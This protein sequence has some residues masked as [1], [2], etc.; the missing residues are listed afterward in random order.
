MS[1]TMKTYLMLGV[2][3]PCSEMPEDIFLNYCETLKGT[4]TRDLIWLKV[5]SLDRSW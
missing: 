4:G 3:I 5:V 1:Q 2:R